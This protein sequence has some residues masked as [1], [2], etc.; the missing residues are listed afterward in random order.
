[1]N[2]PRDATPQFRLHRD[3]AGN[4]VATDQEGRAFTNVKPVRA[5][6][7]SCPDRYISI[8]DAEGHELTRIEDSSALPADVQQLLAEELA[9][10]EFVP[11]VTAVEAVYAEANPSRWHVL[12]DRGPTTFFIND[13]D[14]HVRRVGPHQI[15]LV[16]THG[17]RYLIPDTRRL[18]A[19]STRIL[20]RYL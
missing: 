15:L 4:L 17:I 1:M 12:T 3:P 18:D 9:R 11:V 7:I 6:P 19:A 20:D 8:C 5:F 2:T 16:D 10:N 14:D 13:T